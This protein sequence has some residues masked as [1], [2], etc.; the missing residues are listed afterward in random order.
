MK[1]CIANGCVVIGYEKAT[2]PK[3]DLVKGA[4]GLVYVFGPQFCLPDKA[5][6]CIIALGKCV[7][8]F[9]IKKYF[10]S[11]TKF[12]ACIFLFSVRPV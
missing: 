9:C 5:L 8:I 10:L 7:F 12:V 2:T 3:M 1:V 6:C 11:I 4:C